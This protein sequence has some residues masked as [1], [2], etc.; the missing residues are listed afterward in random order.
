MAAADT[1]GTLLFLLW[2][3][4]SPASSSAAGDSVGVPKQS[5]TVNGGLDAPSLATGAAVVVG[6]F[7]ASLA[8]FA[9]DVYL[10]SKLDQMLLDHYGPELYD[11]YTSKYHDLLEGDGGGGDPDSPVGLTATTR[12]DFYGSTPR[13]E[14]HGDGEGDG[15]GGEGPTSGYFFQLQDHSSLLQ[16]PSFLQR[17]PTQFRG[18]GRTMSRSSSSSGFVSKVRHL[19]QKAITDVFGRR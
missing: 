17:F 5:V 10:T 9:A 18:G 15:G 3:S 11:Q 2:L 7:L 13:W 1:F 6:I 8:L 14:G 12:E 16:P 4:S 19:V